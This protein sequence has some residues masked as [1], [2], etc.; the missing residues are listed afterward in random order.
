MPVRILLLITLAALIAGCLPR[1]VAPDFSR[2]HHARL[3]PDHARMADGVRLPLHRWSNPTPPEIVLIGLHGFNDYSQAFA[4]LAQDLAEQGIW[5]YAVDQRGFGASDRPGHW[6]GSAVLIEDLRT[7][8]ALLRARY[9]R[10]RLVVAGESMGGAVAMAAASAASLPIDG[11]V[12]IAPAVWS[13]DTMPWYQRWALELAT[14]TVPGLELTGK[15]IRLRPS[16]NLDMLRAMSAD[17]LVIKA[18]RVEALW[19]VTSLM[20]LAQ[21]AAPTLPVPTLLLYGE[22]DQIIPKNAFCRMTEALPTS[23]PALRLVL[24]P[25]GW[26]MLPRDLQ[27]TRV[28]ADIAAWLIDPDGPLPSGEETGL[29][30]G[31][32]AAFCDDR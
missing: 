6:P 28:R 2:S 7:L 19:G 30:Q 5:T 31:R 16:D 8:V 17:P 18:T 14:R 21:A 13:R 11:L 3:A 24:Y 9:P 22:R 15:G 4:P 12:L 26:H 23:E 27:G 29:W 20:D 25:D 10:A 1:P 32:H